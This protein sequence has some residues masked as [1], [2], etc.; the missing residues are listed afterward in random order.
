MRIASE[1]YRSWAL[2]YKVELILKDEP[3]SVSIRS[4]VAKSRRFWP[5][6]FSIHSRFLLTPHNCYYR[7]IKVITGMTHDN[8]LTVVIAHLSD[9]P[10]YE[11]IERQIKQAIMTGVLR[12]GDLLPSLRQLAMEL[13]ISVVTT[14]RAY[15]DLEREGFIVTAPGRGT[16]V[17]KAAVGFLRDKKLKLVEDKLIE[18]IDLAQMYGIGRP[19]FMKMIDLLFP[20]RKNE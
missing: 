1:A 3:A 20:R 7:I 15:E 2:P 8:P 18:A 14:N 10:I 4:F 16:Y 9:E 13:K 5:M 19:D 6:P 17:A 11:Q 12:E